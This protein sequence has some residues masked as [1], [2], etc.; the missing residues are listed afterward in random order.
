VCVQFVYCTVCVVYVQGVYSVCTV[1]VQCVYNVCIVC[2]QCVCNVCTVCIKCVYSVCAECVQCV[3][4]VRF[5]IFGRKRNLLTPLCPEENAT[6]LNC[7][8]VVVAF[9]GDHLKCQYVNC[10]F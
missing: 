1:C 2:A 6:D 4:S 5:A 7:Q 3:Y 10:S 9:L 8:Y